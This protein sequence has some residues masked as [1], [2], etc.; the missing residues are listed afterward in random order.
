MSF[1]CGTLDQDVIIYVDVD[2]FQEHD[3]IYFFLEYFSYTSHSKVQF[4]ET[5][6]SL[7]WKG[8]GPFSGLYLFT[9]AARSRFSYLDAKSNW[10]SSVKSGVQFTQ[11][12][13]SMSCPLNVFFAN[14]RRVETS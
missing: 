2:G 1:L 14:V 4:L 10:P 8:C 3:F 11:S 12:G 13:Y 6:E 5:L 7:I 9:I